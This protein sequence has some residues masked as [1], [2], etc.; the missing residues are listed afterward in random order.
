MITVIGK[1]TTF[2]HHG[3]KGDVAARVPCFITK[4][5]QRVR[6]RCQM[7]CRFLPDGQTT[8][9]EPASRWARFIR[10]F[11]VDRK[12]GW[13]T[14]RSFVQRKRVW[15]NTQGCLHCGTMVWLSIYP[16]CGM[17]T[18]LTCQCSCCRHVWLLSLI[19]K[20]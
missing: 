19:R 12:G 6:A 15:K 7:H 20:C 3:K 4:K 18:P 10:W 17:H 16:D 5:L 8:S 9:R 13:T 14:R 2:F 1:T 11:R